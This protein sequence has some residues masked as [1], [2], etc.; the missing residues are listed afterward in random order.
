VFH[1]I[2]TFHHYYS[3]LRFSYRHWY[4]SSLSIIYRFARS[5]TRYESLQ[6]MM[7][8]WHWRDAYDHRYRENILRT[9][10]HRRGGLLFHILIDLTSRLISSWHIFAIDYYMPI[11]SVSSYFRHI[12]AVTPSALH[13]AISYYFHIIISPSLTSYYF[14]III[15]HTLCYYIT[16]AEKREKNIFIFH[17][18][19]FS[20][21]QR[22]NIDYLVA[23]E[24]T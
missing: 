2:L 19:L 6:M 3:P 4:S 11:I 9:R 1:D 16:Y 23:Q 14:N 5:T 22:E 17:I 13:I 15:L 21:T 10:A 18:S 12:D 8:R 20:I 7:S 24:K